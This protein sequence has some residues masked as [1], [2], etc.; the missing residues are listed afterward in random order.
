[1]RL[2]RVQIDGFG[3]LR[4]LN[5]SFLPSVNLFVGD[6]ESGKST[7]QTAILALLYGFY[8]GKRA[9]SS[10]RAQHEKFRPWRGDA[11]GGSLDYLLDDGRAYRIQRSFDTDDVPTSVVDLVTGRDVTREFDVKRHGNVGAARSHLGM[12]QEVFVSTCFVKQAAPVTIGAPQAVAETL[13]S[14]ADTARPDASAANA[15]QL[16]DRARLEQVGTQQARSKPLTLAREKL[17]AAREELRALEADQQ[18]I[19]QNALRKDELESACRELRQQQQLLAYHK[20]TQRLNEIAATL[21]KLREID[22]AIARSAHDA[23]ALR[24]YS[25]FPYEKKDAIVAQKAR[26]NVLVQ[27]QDEQG[28]KR[29]EVESKVQVLDDEIRQ[30]QEVV[31]SPE[32][33]R[34]IPAD[35]E[36]TFS[37]MW[38]SL[39]SCS[40]R[41]V[42]LRQDMSELQSELANRKAVRLL[43]AGS[44]VLALLLA[45]AV[46]SA[47]IA[48]GFAVTGMALALAIAV[49]S[50]SGYAIRRSEPG[51]QGRLGEIKRILQAE[52]TKAADLKQGLV[53]LFQE[54]GIQAPEIEAGV[55]IFRARAASRKRLLDLDDS[56]RTLEERRKGLVSLREQFEDGGIVVKQASEALLGMLRETGIE[57]D[58]IQD[59]ITRFEECH[60]KRLRYD[61]AQHYVRVWTGQ[62]EAL[63]SHQIEASLIEQRHHLQAQVSAILAAAPQFKGA[64]TDKTPTE[65]EEQER[66]LQTRTSETEL[67]AARLDTAIKTTLGKHRPRCELEEDLARCEAEVQK[68][69]KF[70]SALLLAAKVLQE[71]ADEV[72]RDFAPRLGQAVGHSLATITDGRYRTALVDVS[73]FGVKLESVEAGALVDA[74]HLST[75]TQDQAYLLLRI[76]LAR[77]LSISNQSLPL[78]LDDPFVNFDE[79]RLGN[80]LQLLVGVSRTNQVL[81]FTKDPS[82]PEWFRTHCAA[83]DIYQL[84]E[85]PAHRV[86]ALE[87]TVNP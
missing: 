84:L 20:T 1:M 74:D 51:D 3:A 79:T 70:A 46:A 9:T 48:A 12:R 85:L 71:A 34:Q 39:E 61:D 40:G 64:V 50:I 7:F 42:Q 11:F 17:E 24:D 62:R 78:I 73:D 4:G 29:E 31:E 75:G 68:L 18:L 30:A 53:G 21:D 69:E 33:A 81:L 44:L 2:N 45:A 86:A 36:D 38:F 10:E 60:R 13:V 80:M 87:P 66:V 55:D 43:S 19:R 28:H 67:D 32:F 58:N 5:V 27:Q 57:T 8:Q 54:V 35:K 76:E 6:N 25:S 41:V 56:L 82:I 26:L 65:L 63:L 16:L 72:H 59:G 47:S 77:M 37:R 14:L 49:A 22:A 15:V 52:E 23:E 83:D